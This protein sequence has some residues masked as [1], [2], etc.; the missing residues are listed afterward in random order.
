M[1][2]LFNLPECPSPRLRWMQNHNLRTRLNKNISV[3]EEDEFSGEPIYPWVA[4]TGDFKFPRP[5]AGYGNTEDEA[6]TAWA[7]LHRVKLWN[8]EDL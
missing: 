6:I 5:D 1:N 3:G 2:D 4:F 7:K 8:E